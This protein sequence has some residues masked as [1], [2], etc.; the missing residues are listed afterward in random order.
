MSTTENDNDQSFISPSRALNRMAN[1]FIHSDSIV[2]RNPTVDLVN[3]N[4]RQTST[5]V[6]FLI[7]IDRLFSD[8]LLSLCYD[9]I[10]I[11]LLCLGLSY[12]TKTC[13]ISNALAIISILIVVV[14]TLQLAFTLLFL[15]PNWHLRHTSLSDRTILRQF[16]QGRT[17]RVLFRFIRF[18]CICVG[19]AYVFPPKMPTNND[20]E[21]IRFYL[22]IVCFNGWLFIIFDPAKP[23]LPVRRPII[24]E[25]FASLVLIIYNGI[26][27]G[28]VLFALMKSKKSE[29]VYK[30]IEDLYFDA[31]LQSFAYIGI[32][33]VVCWIL[34]TT[35]SFMINQQYYRLVTL[36][37]CFI[38]LSAIAYAILYL[39]TLLFNYYYSVGAVLLF[40]PRLGGSCRLVDDGLYTTLLIWQIIRC[41]S[42]IILWLLTIVV[43]CGGLTVGACLI[44]YLSPWIAVPLFEM[45]HVSLVLNI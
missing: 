30:R 2:E 36:R 5:W 27:I 22:G 43:C 13:K 8:G 10:N 12:G 37:R 19:T 17:V 42:I 39:T 14:T 33:L 35:F 15:K 7:E 1:T 16:S 4:D 34:S 18:V 45:L 41:F 44:G 24:L 40:K 28:F 38:H 11:I 20:C 31:P 9:L 3:G 32:I 6:D 23:S 26:H 25:F 29:C 21:I